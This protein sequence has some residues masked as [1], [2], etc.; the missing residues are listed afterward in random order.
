LCSSNTI[1]IN[2]HP[3]FTQ[4]N[5]WLQVLNLLPFV[6]TVANCLSWVAYSFIIDNWYLFIP[7]MLGFLIGLMLFLISFGIGVSDAAV[8]NRIV[9][10]SMVLATLLP[11]VAAIE[12]L[13]LDS[14]EAQKQLWGYTGAWPLVLLLV[15]S[16]KNLYPRF[17][18]VWVP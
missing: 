12:R 4:C 13:I 3:S 10:V 6:F 2:V 1:A 16:S 7:N 18:Y 9:A 8:R 17:Q 5:V 14:H 15:S 11:T